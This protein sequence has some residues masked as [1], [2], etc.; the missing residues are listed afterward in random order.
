VAPKLTA[1]FI[2]PFQTQRTKRQE[3]ESVLIEQNTL[4]EEARG[5]HQGDDHTQGQTE[6]T[7]RAKVAMKS[8]KKQQTRNEN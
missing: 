3:H 1:S 5:G 8:A 7:C 2:P 6:T 4:E